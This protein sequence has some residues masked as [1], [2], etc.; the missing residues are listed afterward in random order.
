MNDVGIAKLD[1]RDE[2]RLLRTAS[3][4][5]FALVACKLLIHLYAGRHYGYFVD[6]LYYL[7]AVVI[8]IGATSTSRR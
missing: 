5:V 1:H 4:T 2:R 3:G 8:W 6:E 7:L